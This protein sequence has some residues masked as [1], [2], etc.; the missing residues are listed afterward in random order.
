[1]CQVDPVD[2]P[3]SRQQLRWHLTNAGG[4]EKD[5]H[6]PRP[7]DRPHAQGAGGR[8]PASSGQYVL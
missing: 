1:M 4:G 8:P 7:L 5:T 2:V 3:T 6:P